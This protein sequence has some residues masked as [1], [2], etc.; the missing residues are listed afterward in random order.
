MDKYLDFV[1]DNQEY[2][3]IDQGDDDLS[4][5]TETAQIDDSAWPYY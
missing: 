2:K 3:P 5:S 1:M 4:S